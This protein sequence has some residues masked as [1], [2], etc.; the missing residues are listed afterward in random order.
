MS[1]QKIFELEKRIAAL[2]QQVAELKNIGHPAKPTHTYDQPVRTDKPS[3]QFSR[4]PKPIREDPI[5]WEKRIGQVWLPRIFIFVL[6][7]GVIWAFK[8]AA[9]NSLI[10][11]PVRVLLGFAAAAGL[12]FL[13]D[14]QI[15][16]NRKV[17]GITLLSG[18]VTTFILSTFA[19][20][21]L[22]SFISIYPAMVLNVLGIA[23][24]VYFTVR[25][26]SQALGILVAAGGYL[27]PFLL[28][29]EQGN[30]YLFAAYVFLLYMSLFA[31]SLKERFIILLYSSIVFL[32]LTY[33]AYAAFSGFGLAPAELITSLKVIAVSVLLQQLITLA[34]LAKFDRFHS[35]EFPLLFSSA[36]VTLPWLYVA[37]NSRPAQF[38]GAAYVDFSNDFFT[39]YDGFWIGLFLFYTAL[40]LLSVRNKTGGKLVLFSSVAVFILSVG[41]FRLIDMYELK[42]VFLVESVIL[43]YLAITINSRFQRAG[44]FLLLFFSGWMTIEE[45]LL[46]ERVWSFETLTF[47]ILLAALGTIYR[48]FN[49]RDT[50]IS[51][52]SRKTGRLL[53][54]SSLVGTLLVFLTVVADV[55]LQAYSGNLQSMGVSVVWGLFSISSVF[56]GMKTG[57]RKIRIFGIALIFVTLLKL[58]FVDMHFVSIVIRSFLFITLGVIGIVMSRMFYAAKTE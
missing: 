42:A 54:G 3:W 13:G 25:H 7:L 15:S 29:N 31:L 6:L 11:E 49:D 44:A 2:E 1:E 28:E 24:G 30:V 48:L 22:Y 8:A 47:L 38:Q 50:I 56:Y 41:L 33:S 55:G 45:G 12:A 36:A 9:D 17:L 5:D 16:G 4:N 46:M 52:D 39:A 26:K 20:H 10:T 34:V 27:V 58:L 51:S 43:Y 40:S 57:N 21:V 23:G 37:F 32:H 19:A 14:R 18:A 35:Q 53:L